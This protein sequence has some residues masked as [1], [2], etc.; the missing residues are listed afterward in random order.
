MINKTDSHYVHILNKKYQKGYNLDKFMLMKEMHE[1]L[2]T[3]RTVDE[4]KK[5]SKH[6]VEANTTDTLK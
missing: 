6:I 1:K 5:Y 3:K 4:L 2:L